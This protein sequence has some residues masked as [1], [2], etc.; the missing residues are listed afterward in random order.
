MDER[1]PRQPD[2]S[3]PPEDSDGTEARRPRPENPYRI[4]AR[5][6]GARPSDTGNFGFEHPRPADPP[7]PPVSEPSAPA[8]SWGADAGQYGGE[9]SDGDDGTDDSWGAPYRGSRQESEPESAPAA[10]EPHEPWGSPSAPRS[11]A[12]S[13]DAPSESRAPSD[14]P[15]VSETW[16]TAPEPSSDGWDAP[17]SETSRSSSES[18][19]GSAD[20]QES[21]GTPVAPQASE[22]WGSAPEP[23]AARDEW[24]TPSG[25]QAPADSWGSASEP[26]SP[27]YGW[28]D[29]SGPQT[30]TDSWGTP[31]T[32][33]ASESWGSAPEPQAAREEWNT[34]S[35]PQAPADS[36]SS[37]SQA[38]GPGWGSASEPQSPQ[39]GWNDPSGPQTPTDG[40]GTPVPPPGSQER[41][42]ASGEEPYEPWGTPVAPRPQDTPGHAPEDGWAQT[43]QGHESVGAAHEAWQTPYAGQPAYQG[44]TPYPGSAPEPS[45]GSE[46]RERDGRGE[47]Y[48]YL[49]GGAGQDG[50]GGPEGPKGPGGPDDYDAYDDYDP[51]PPPRKSR[52]GLV[53]G[54]VATVVVLALVG[55][56]AGWYVYTLP[57]PEEAT[58]EFEA[59]WEEQDFARLAAVT[60][61]DDAEAILGGI[62]SGLGVDGVDVEV[63]SPTTDGGTGSAPYEVTLSLTNAS[64][65][66]WEGEL[67]LLREDGEWLVE[68]S[69]E[70]AYPGL[71]EGQT[72]TRT[73]VWGERGQVLAADGT[74]LDAADVS[75]SIQMIVGEL[76]EA[77]EED[78]ERLG[79][80]YK[81]GDT[82][83]KTGLQRTYEERL[84]GEAAATIVMVDAAEIEDGQAPEVTEEN[85]VASLDGSDGESVTT[86]FD[87][88]VQSAAANAII[89]ADDPAGL[90]AIRPSS[91]EILAAV[92]VPGGFNRA[93]E[94][95]YPP[96]SSFKIVTYSALLDNGLSVDAS[97]DCPEEYELG[98]WPFRNAGG[99]EYGQQSVTEAFATSCNTALVHEIGQVLSPETLQASAEQFGMNAP[100]D[101]GVSTQEPSFPAVD[102]TTMMGAQGIGQGQILTSPLHMATVPA[103]VAD[104]AWRQPVLVTEP[105]RDDLREPQTIGNAEALR[106]MM[107]EVITDGTAKDAGFQGEVFGKTGSAEFGTADDADEDDELPTHAWMVGYKGDVAF[108]L[109]VEGGGGGGSVAGP[110]AA[111]FTN[112]L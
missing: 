7:A 89:D 26:Q 66:G 23:Q 41:P 13:W 24:N 55:A 73:A 2:S 44:D 65:F 59:A 33:Q 4:P 78:V 112:A 97:M 110:L 70:V 22:S 96:G 83:G 51:G 67:P 86:S 106:P 34:P 28:N 54:V 43:A 108:A 52:R 15:T 27:Q 93:F 57:Q 84:A 3:G 69:P 87:M 76:G 98:G 102:S 88:G 75:G 49:Y 50:P 19:T 101:I 103:A 5:P 107:R 62:D 9:A 82:V 95:Q 30:P 77:D 92:N 42:N 29:P 17:A 94:G 111:K 48:E 64:D 36:W 58:T 104:G 40:W 79:P 60:T 72:L 25:P 14:S 90:V 63:G 38:S 8:E 71:G 53:I 68:F 12:E 105:A 100:L 16:G 6:S 20:P 45:A 39:Y 47:G 31:A 56:G 61:G 11:S 85:T 99:A 21:W 81:V 35:G 37:P 80:A 74:R 1:S 10:P 91:G 46:G 32:P 109:V 18:W